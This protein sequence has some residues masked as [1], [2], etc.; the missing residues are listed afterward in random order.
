MNI[1]SLLSKKNLKSAAVFIAIWT[2]SIWLLY[3]LFVL[4]SPDDWDPESFEMRSIFGI[5]LLLIILGKTIFDIF[6]PLDTSKGLSWFQTIFLTL[7][8]VAIVIGIIFVAGRMIV[9]YFTSEN[10]ELFFG[11]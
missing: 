3:P 6:F 1:R 8:S 10:S 11:F 7:Y 5:G 2:L 9:L 4:Q